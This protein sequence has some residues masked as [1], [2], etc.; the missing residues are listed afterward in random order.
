M[1]RLMIPLL[2]VLALPATAAAKEGAI[3][4]P[5]LSSLVPG[6]Q[7]LVQ[8]YIAPV[9]RGGRTL[10]P[11]PRDG[12][13]PTVV[14][15]SADRTLRFPAG[16]LRGGAAWVDITVPSRVRWH[17]SVTVG[18]RRYPSEMQRSFV[19]GADAV[20]IA[21]APD[22]PPPVRRAEAAGIPG[23]PFAAGGVLAAALVGLWWRRGHG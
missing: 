11:A 15:R 9:M 10:V 20:P 5:A 4:S 3:F 17:A 14:L 2:A 22:P 7:T 8:V 23:W 12:E 21:A 19:G 16:P 1:R 6:E 13:K 18:S